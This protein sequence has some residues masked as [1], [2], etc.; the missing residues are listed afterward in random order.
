MNPRHRAH[1]LSP[2]KR[3]V[4]SDH[5]SIRATSLSAEGDSR[6]LRNRIF[7]EIRGR[8]QVQSAATGVRIQ[9]CGND[10]RYYRISSLKYQPGDKENSSPWAKNWEAG[11]KV[12]RFFNKFA[13]AHQR[14]KLHFEVSFL[15]ADLISRYSAG[16]GTSGRACYRLSETKR[17]EP[18]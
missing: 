6:M 2:N 5:K 13:T 4:I 12:L 9:Y 3:E 14:L 11:L 15:V 10:V 1:V 7:S 16:E 8:G 17:F 18:R